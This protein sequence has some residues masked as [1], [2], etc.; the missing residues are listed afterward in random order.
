MMGAARAGG[1]VVQAL[2]AVA[3]TRDVQVEGVNIPAGARLLLVVNSANHDPRHFGDPDLFDIRRDNAVEHL[4]FGFGAHQCLG[5]NIGRMEMQ[6]IIGELTRRLPH[7]RLATQEFEY[8]HNLAFRGPHALL[9]EWDPAANPERRDPSVRRWQQEV[10]LGAPLA[11]NIVRNLQVEGLR[12][13]AR[14]TILLRLRSPHGSALPKW[15]PGAHID[16]ECGDSSLARQYSLCSDP[17]ER[18]AWEVAVLK[19]PASRG[20]S[21]WLHANAKPGATLRV[22]GPRNHFRMDEGHDGRYVF[23]AG[24]IGI[25]PVM[26]MAARARALGR[27]YEFHYCCRTK[28]WMAFADELR[29]LHGDRLRLHLSDEGSRL[30]LVALA[31]EL[32]G[33]SVQVYACGP[34]RM[35]DALQ[36]AVQAAGL[37][38]TALHVEHFSNDRP[39][40]DP[41][42]EVPFEVELRNS[43]LTITVPNDRS[44]LETLRARNVDVQS[45]CE[46]GLCGLCQVEVVSGEVD[47]R[48]SILSPTERRENTRMMACCSRAREGGKL[49]LDL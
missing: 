22:R 43:G 44:L 38:E 23:V 15:T 5:K 37:P 32:M 30:D 29:A 25:T 19:D 7:M 28:E 45:D 36:A 34:E 40:L 17:D 49:V 48:D 20:G 12:E 46:E 16:I 31:R 41:S 33:E 35:L 3:R 14:D 26:T 42:R 27:D 6:I 24:G 39:K 10:R 21:A 2:F 8:V 9:V 18:G 47:H 11:R 4:S 1:G 13:V